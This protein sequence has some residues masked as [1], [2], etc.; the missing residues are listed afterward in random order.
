MSMGKVSWQDRLR[1]KFDN[2]LSG[3]SAAVIG[4][5]AAL[6]VAVILTISL[7]VW[8]GQIGPSDEEPMTLSEAI[9]ASLMRTL[10]PGTMG[11]DTGWRFRFAMLAVTLGGIFVISTFIG[12]ITNSIDN[13]L[14]ELRK[15]RSRVVESGHLVLL[16]WSEHIFTVLHELKL[17]AGARPD[18]VVI[19]GNKDKVEMEDSIRERLGAGGR[20]RIV[21]RSG[22]AIEHTDLDIVSLDSARAIIV[23]SPDLADGDRDAQV[24]K[25]LLAIVNNPLRRHG[26]YHIVAELRDPR[27]VDVARLISH[28]EVTFVVAGDL[29][30]RI[31]AQTSRQ[32]GLATVY[33]ELLSYEGSEIYLTDQPELAGKTFSDALFAFAGATVIGVAAHNGRPR[34][35]PPLD[36][37]I[38]QHDR[39]VVIAP[40][41]E[42]LRADLTTPSFD[43][44]AIVVQ[45]VTAPAP[46]RTLVLGW[47][48][49]VPSILE[50]LDAYVAP[51]SEVVVV[52]DIE[53]AGAAVALL[54][55]RLQRFVPRFQFG[56]TTDRR[57]L[58]ELQVESYQHV[59]LMCYDNV[60]PQEADARTMVTLLH[61]RDIASR[62]GHAF[63]I[64]SEM[65][66]VRNR[67][68]VEIAQPDDFIVSDQL[69]SLV[70][71]Q[72]AEVKEL[73]DVFAELFDAQGV[74]IYIKPAGE[75]VRLGVP[76]SFYTVVE[77][78]R[79]RGETAIGFRRIE[80]EAYARN[81]QGIVLNPHKSATLTFGERDRIIV[82]AED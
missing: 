48:W 15:G 60:P 46:D 8:L 58:D 10:D 53:A 42:S 14:D 22:D 54:A 12:V 82:V 63:S 61:L 7:L 55:A 23:L 68:L 32:A 51:G 76:V 16:N 73:N 47:N 28:D 18:C 31:I 3:G 6:S 40:E 17:A 66:D 21:C 33:T 67:R 4:W 5:L 57:L 11:G 71:A 74:E 62:C 24:L 26:S 80:G 27:H 29:V 39:L 13:K 36:T 9:W 37:V 38:G 34:L 43:E 30:A 59:V 19:L 52:A 2:T 77:A 49:R 20:T 64:V 35:N 72:L 41:P 44:A 25:T 50:Q 70:L 78:A 56:N 69:V 81:N 79:R 75:Y 45:P 65:L 1:Y